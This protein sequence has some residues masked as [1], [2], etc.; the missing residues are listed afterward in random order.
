MH[1]ASNLVGI[2]PAFPGFFMSM[3]FPGK[4]TYTGRDVC[5]GL[6]RWFGEMEGVLSQLLKEPT[7]AYRCHYSQNVQ[8]LLQDEVQ[9]L[10]VVRSPPPPPPQTLP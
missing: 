9:A 3:N 5:D 2:A 8:P 4:R 1:G 6:Y 10:F 7:T